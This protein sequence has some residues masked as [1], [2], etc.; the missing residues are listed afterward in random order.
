MK[1]SLLVRIGKLLSTAKRL[2]RRRAKGRPSEA[3]KP[4]I[5][6]YVNRILSDAILFNET[7]ASPDRTIRRMDFIVQRLSEFGY[8]DPRID[9][10]G[11]VSIIVPA[12]RPTN[13]HALLLADIGAGVDSPSDCF[14]TLEAGRARGGG[15]AE[16]S[17]GVAALL[18]LAEYIAAAGLT[19]DRNL[20]L[21]FSCF[22]PGQREAQP[23][24][25]FLQGW[26]GRL[27]FA[28][29]VRSLALGRIQDRPMGTCK[30][31]VT[32][33][34]EQRDLMRS[35]GAASAISVLAAAASRLGSIR[36]DAEGNTFLNIAR[37]EAGAGFGWYAAEGVLELEIFSTDASALEVA[38]KA[39]SATIGT[40]ASEAGARAE[41]A[42]KTFYPVG[43]PAGNTQMNAGLNDALRRVYARLRIKPQPTSVP[44]HSAFINSLGIPS[45]SLGITTGSRSLTEES[46]DTKPIEAGFRQLLGFLDETLSRAGAAA[47]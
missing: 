39:V 10:W 34:T 11:N 31:C 23:L 6:S 46:V 26:K 45:V 5:G 33:R 2:F 16:N 20:V 35:E 30:L 8:P 43:N 25:R 17:V 12:S 37:L 13:D 7:Q 1:G 19:Y 41:V 47:P 28:A 18:V 29:Y 3:R 40:V 32:V 27:L 14:V 24:E 21:L 9:Q 22:D 42:V 36:W 44:D 38:R 15:L 4:G